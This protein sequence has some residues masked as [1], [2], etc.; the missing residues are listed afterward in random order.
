VGEVIPA[1]RERGD[2]RARGDLK[3]HCDIGIARDHLAEIGCDQPAG[4]E[5]GGEVTQENADEDEG[6]VCCPDGDEWRQDGLG[7]VVRLNSENLNQENS[8]SLCFPAIPDTKPLRT[9]AGIA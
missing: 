3:G 8:L 2:E 1:F 7:R 6:H 9:F 4:D 5:D